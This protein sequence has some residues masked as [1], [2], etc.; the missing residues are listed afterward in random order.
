ML[1]ISCKTDYNFKINAPSKINSN[2]KLTIS[3][4]EKGGTP[5]DSVRVTLNNKK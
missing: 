5:I 3:F 1:V 4:T 2:K